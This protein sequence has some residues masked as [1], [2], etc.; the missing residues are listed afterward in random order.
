L[1]QPAR[2]ISLRSCVARH[3]VGSHTVP[4]ALVGECFMPVE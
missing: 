4:G 1:N 2:L 3:G